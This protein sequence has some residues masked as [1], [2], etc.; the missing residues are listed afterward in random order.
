MNSDTL[1]SLVI[2]INNLVKNKKENHETKTPPQDTSI[3]QF[4]KG[5]VKG[6]KSKYWRET[7][8]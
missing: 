7:R 3:P 5:E 1:T 6:R 4:T 8:G 2:I